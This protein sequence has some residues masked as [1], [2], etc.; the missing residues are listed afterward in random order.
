MHDKV[1]TQHI[2][3]H[4]RISYL[5]L[6]ILQS[7]CK[8]LHDFV[9]SKYPFDSLLSHMDLKQKSN[10]PMPKQPYIM[11][12]KL[13]YTLV[14]FHVTIPIIHAVRIRQTFHFETSNF[15]VESIP[16]MSSGAATSSDVI[17]H[18]TNCV[19]SAF[20]LRA[21]V[22]T[23][24]ASTNQ[25]I[26]A[27]GIARALIWQNASRLNERIADG[28]LWANATVRAQL[29]DTSCALVTGRVFALIDV[30]TT[31]R[32]SD[33]AV[34]ALALVPYAYFRLTAVRVSSTTR[35]TGSF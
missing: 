16:K 28:S 35:L 14:R 33:K 17:K 25:I 22:H 24:P 23:F 32:C 19:R 4:R 34:S 2:H 29:V 1:A 27:V 8:I 18:V 20:D 13:T 10:N 31:L 21:R 11:T 30:H 26:G 12:I 6:Y 3:P 9:Y 5:Q 7:I 15:Q